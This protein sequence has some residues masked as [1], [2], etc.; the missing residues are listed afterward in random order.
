M[1]TREPK[2]TETE[3]DKKYKQETALASTPTPSRNIIGGEK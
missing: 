3:S 2:V 1:Q